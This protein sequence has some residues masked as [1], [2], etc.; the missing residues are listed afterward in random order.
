MATQD[1]LFSDGANL[2]AAADY[3]AKQFYAV[4]V[5]TAADRTALLAS[6]QGA[7]IY[8]VL[9]NK[10][11]AAQ[12]TDIGVWGVTKMIAGAAITRGAELMVDATGKFITWTSASAYTKVGIALESAAGSGTIFTGFVYGPAGPQVIT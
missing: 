3:S 6:S 5:S 1:P 9:Q 11:K 10:P 8:G 7:K 4:G 12:I 2:V